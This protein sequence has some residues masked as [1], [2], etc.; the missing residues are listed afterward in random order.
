MNRDRHEAQIQEVFSG[1]NEV[2]LWK[3]LLN[4]T[5]QEKEYIINEQ[6]NIFNK[7]QSIMNKI[8]KMRE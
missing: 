4:D 1:T 6:A 7:Y 3:E 8:N 5:F 2:K